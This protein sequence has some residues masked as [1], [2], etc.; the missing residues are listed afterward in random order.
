MNLPNE[1]K[2]KYNNISNA[3]TE[4]VVEEVL[5]SLEVHKIEEIIPALN[6]IRKAF[7]SFSKLN[8]LI[9]NICFIIFDCPKQKYDK[10]VFFII[11][12]FKDSK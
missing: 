8:D 6:Y 4:K 2:S 11:E 9:K 12:Y 3:T 10:K 1:N 7:S 5:K